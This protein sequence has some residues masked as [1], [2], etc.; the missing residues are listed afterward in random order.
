MPA[1]ARTKGT[2]LNKE[3]QAY[4]LS[5]YANRITGDNI[6]AW[7]RRTTQLPGHNSCPIQFANDQDWLANTYF[8]TNKDGR[9]NR[10][11]RYCESHPTWPEGP[12]KSK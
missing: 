1:Q 9:L 6:P 12:P 8:R 11:A 10:K 7:M 5:A 3:D 2:D 4:V